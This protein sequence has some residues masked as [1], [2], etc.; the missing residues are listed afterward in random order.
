MTEGESIKSQWTP[1]GVFVCLST[2]TDIYL[3]LNFFK[4]IYAPPV[5]NQSHT[6]DLLTI[7]QTLF[8]CTTLEPNMSFFHIWI[9]SCVC[10]VNLIWYRLQKS[11]REDKLTVYS[12]NAS[13][14]LRN[15]WMESL[16]RYLIFSETSLIHNVHPAPIQIVNYVMVTN[17]LHAQE[18]AWPVVLCW[19]SAEWLQ[20]RQKHRRGAACQCVKHCDCPLDKPHIHV[21]IYYKP[22][23]FNISHWEQTVELFSSVIAAVLD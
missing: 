20:V 3:N 21:R 9:I 8:C 13:Y 15:L 2:V 5:Y 14:T 12:I 23:W 1:W 6:C 11:S 17:W 7:G 18:P 22:F 10:I 16:F 4:N 19:N